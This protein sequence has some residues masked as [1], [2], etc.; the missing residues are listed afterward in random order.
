MKSPFT[1]GGVRLIQEPRELV[2]RKE[3][4]AYVAHYYVCADTQEQFTTTKIDELNINQVYNQY[5]WRQC[6]MRLSL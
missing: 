1:G 5:C 2:F 6:A 4:F 3:R